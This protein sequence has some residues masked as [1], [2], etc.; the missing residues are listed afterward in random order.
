[1]LRCSAETMPAVTV[2]PRPKGLPIGDDPVA[3]ARLGRIAELDEGQRLLGHDLEHGEV[4]RGVGADQLRLDIRVR[5]GMMTVIESTVAPRAP[6]ADHVVVGDDVA[7]GRDDE[8]RTE[9]LRLARLGALPP[10]WPPGA[11]G[12]PWPP[13]R[14]PNGVPEKGLLGTCTRWRGRDVDHG[15]LEPLDHVGKAAGARRGAAERPSFCAVWAIRMSGD[16]VR[17]S[18]VPP[19]SRAAVMA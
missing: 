12:A 10:P 13:N 8:A 5:S 7:V 1:M 15:R 9:R 18:V 2:P 3:D 16:V 17:A 6:G 11:P 4:A 19:R 14:S